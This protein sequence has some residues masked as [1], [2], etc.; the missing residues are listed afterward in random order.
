MALRTTI[1]LS[2]I[3]LFFQQFYGFSEFGVDFLLILVVLKGIRTTPANA[4]VYGGVIGFFQDALSSSWIGPNMVAKIL[5]SFLVS[6]LKKNFYREKI[7]TQ[8][9]LISIT[10]FFQQII[11]L[12]ILNLCSRQNKIFSISLIF[13]PTIM[14]SIVGALICFVV[15]QF[16]HRHYDPATA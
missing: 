9:L 14:T 11:I 3:A 6:L 2:V 7:W 12:I 16:R 15:V 10:M 13:K 4:V 8:T 1:I 5:I